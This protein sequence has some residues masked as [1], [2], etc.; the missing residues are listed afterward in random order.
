M[1]WPSAQK[2]ITGWQKPRHRCFTTR[3]EAQR[4]LNEDETRDL[5]NGST[6]NGESCHSMVNN[7]SDRPFG[8]GSQESVP[9]KVRKTTKGMKS[10]NL[11]FSEADFEPGTGPLPPDA[12]DGFDPNIML[13][14]GSGKLVYKT[15]EQ[16]QATKLRPSAAAQ[17]EPIRIFTDGSSLGNGRAGAF[18][19]V[20]VYFGP[21]DKRYNLIET[22][23]I[24][25]LFGLIDQR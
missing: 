19:G 9:K 10:V 25:V 2:Q 22:F 12:E 14:P 1:D 18:A 20:G 4:F 24:I 23:H 5:D 21:G 7:T 16:R 13:D 15:Q 8:L 6:L 11:V 3:A 17:T